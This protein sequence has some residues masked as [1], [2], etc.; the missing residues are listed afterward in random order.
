M[1][2]NWRILLN[3]GPYRRF[4]KILYSG[5]FSGNSVYFDHNLY[6]FH[7]GCQRHNYI[8]LRRIGYSVP[9]K[10]SGGGWWNPA[11]SRESQEL[12]RRCTTPE[13]FRKFI[14]G[15]DPWINLTLGTI[16]KWFSWC[17]KNRWKFDFGEINN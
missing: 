15:L 3:S 1:R 9:E 10:H 17:L 11:K 14:S 8:K 13:L 16:L 6:N 4:R 5:I 12:L 2:I 7:Q